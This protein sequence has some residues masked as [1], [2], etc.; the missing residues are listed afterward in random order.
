MVVPHSSSSTLNTDISKWIFF[1]VWTCNCN[2]ETDSKINLHGDERV[3]NWSS[4]VLLSYCFLFFRSLFCCLFPRSFLSMLH[5]HSMVE[6][7]QNESKNHQNCTFHSPIPLCIYNTSFIHECCLE[8]GINCIRSTIAGWNGYSVISSIRCLY[9][10][11]WK[12]NLIES[13]FS[14]YSGLKWFWL[15]PANK[16]IIL[17]K[18]MSKLYRMDWDG[19]GWDRMFAIMYTVK[20]LGEFSESILGNPKLY[21]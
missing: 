6:M 17:Y 19:M 4:S 1:Y 8:M 10:S 15:L 9:V 2:N 20:Y 11:K 13:R 7:L 21:P 14:M 3:W 12:W 5:W 18:K 16:K